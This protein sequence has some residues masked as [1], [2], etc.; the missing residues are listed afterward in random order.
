MTSYAIKDL[1]AAQQRLQAITSRWENYSGNN[2]NK[3]QAEMRMAQTAVRIIEREL[4]R[5]GA[6]DYTPQEQ[7]TMALDR[8]FPNADSNT[9]VEHE[10]V[11]YQRKYLKTPDG[12]QG[13]WAEMIARE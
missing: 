4:K 13:Y 12:W 8:R 5:S 10:G 9:I 11:S 3:Y 1:Q 2:P 6:I 7:L